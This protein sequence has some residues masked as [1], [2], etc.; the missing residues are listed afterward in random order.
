MVTFRI[1]AEILSPAT[2]VM[3]AHN[4]QTDQSA[5]L[6]MWLSCNN[7][8]YY[9]ID[10]KNC[11][12]Y[13]IE[14][15]KFNRRF[16]PDVYLG[17]AAVIT[18][19]EKEREVRCG[20]LISKPRRHQLKDDRK[21][22]LVMNRLDETARL[23][24]QLDNEKIGNIQGMEF[25]AEAIANMHRYLDQ[26]PS[27][28]ST[29]A[30]LSEKLH[31][32]RQKFMKALHEVRK[33]EEFATF[34]QR[35][36]RKVMH[37]LMT[38]GKSLEQLADAYKHVFEN[39]IQAKKIRR[40]HGDLKTTNLWLNRIADSMQHQVLFLDCVDFN[41]NFYHIDTLSDVAMMAVDLEMRLA[42]PL[43]DSNSPPDSKKLV[44]H[45]L[46]TYLRVTEESEAVWPLLEY[47]MTEKAMV[48]AYM[49]ILFDRLSS[50]G[51]KY[52]DVVLIHSQKL[53]DYLPPGVGKR[54]TRPLVSTKGETIR[55]G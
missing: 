5:C 15:L 32:N 6:K 40:C 28:M 54:I 20:R 9:T 41:P 47:Y 52:L 30:N 29:P 49:S 18:R 45:F 44:K 8:L 53:A 22:V 16:A 4:K 43:D 34:R 2:H 21:Y 17:L 31:F 25:L 36:S 1:E 42:Y 50:L 35:I 3:I 13:F 11:N 33:K 48:C 27:G 10:L 55:R 46:H 38:T 51:E 14:G 12:D 7:G 19:N 23:D 39:R 26:S 24:Y 37:S